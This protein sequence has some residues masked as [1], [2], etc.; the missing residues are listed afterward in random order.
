MD[1]IA[2][3]CYGKDLLWLQKNGNAL[4]KQHKQGSALVR[5]VSNGNVGK[6]NAKEK[7]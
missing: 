2:T 6:T 4:G 3:R 1:R 7:L 5:G